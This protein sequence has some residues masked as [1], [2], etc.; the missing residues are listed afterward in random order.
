MVTL[1]NTSLGASSRQQAKLSQR[2]FA[3]K[4]GFIC[5]AL[6]KENWQ[7]VL[8]RPELPDGFQ[9]RVF[10]GKGHRMREQLMD[11][12]LMGWWRGNRVMF[13]ES[14]SGFRQSGVCVPVVKSCPPPEWGV[15]VCVLVS[16]EQLRDKCQIVLCVLQEERGVL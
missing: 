16:A 9:A 8:K 2:A 7:C 14:P 4:S 15:C 5:E 3:A 13:Q 12:L 11:L 10:G 6:S 1:R